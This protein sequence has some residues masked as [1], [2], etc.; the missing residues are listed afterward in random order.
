MYP[1]HLRHTLC[2]VRGNYLSNTNANFKVRN[3]LNG[4]TV[5]TFQNGLQRKTSRQVLKLLLL[6]KS[7]NKT[8]HSRYHSHSIPE[9]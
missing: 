6:D 3:T 2:R 8:T 4:A 1:V 7:V 5:D 9:H